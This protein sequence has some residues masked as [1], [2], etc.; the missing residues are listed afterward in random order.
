MNTNRVSATLSTTDQDAVMTA[1]ATIREKLPFL[2]DLST[3]ERASMLKLGDK[4]LAFV[5]KALEV[6]AQHP[7]LVP[8]PLLEEMRK[9]AHLFDTLAPIRLAVDH[10]K[11]Q[12]NDTATQAGGEAFAAARTIYAM[13][14]TPLA[15][16]S[17]SPAADDLG[18]RFG[19]RRIAQAP[20]PEPAETPAP[21]SP[22]APPEAASA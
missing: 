4:S 5:K 16:A 19:R 22:P 15:K 2:I 18:K 21:A 13:T 1:I 20:E 3:T 12:L 11:K 14:K 7:Q 9:D 8:A 6:A 17:L 10:L